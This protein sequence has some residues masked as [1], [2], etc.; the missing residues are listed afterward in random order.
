MKHHRN[1]KKEFRNIP[2]ALPFMKLQKIKHPKQINTHPQISPQASHK[3]IQHSYSTQINVS[4]MAIT[5][6][7]IFAEHETITTW[8]SKSYTLYTD[9]TSGFSLNL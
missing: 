6:M 8:V 2:T 4:D 3:T 9:D 7:D 1:I 5:G